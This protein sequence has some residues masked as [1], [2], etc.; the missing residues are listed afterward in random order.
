MDSESG[1]TSICMNFVGFR[2]CQK[3]YNHNLSDRMPQM[4]VQSPESVPMMFSDAISFAL[5][6]LSDSLREHNHNQTK[7]GNLQFLESRRGATPFGRF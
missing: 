4:L 5:R 2:I 3:H 1:G 7:I 6:W